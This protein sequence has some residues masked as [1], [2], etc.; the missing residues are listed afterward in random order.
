MSKGNT[1]SQMEVVFFKCAGDVQIHPYQR[2]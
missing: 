2:A 1:I